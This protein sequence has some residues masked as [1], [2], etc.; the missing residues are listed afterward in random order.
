MNVLT[1]DDL[2]SIAPSI[3]TASPY[4]TMT[5]R[6]RV[7]HTA[8][9][10][11]VLERIGLFPVRAQQSRTRTPDRKPYVRHLIRFRRQQD[12]NADLATEIPEVVLSNSFDGTSAYR[13]NVGLF[14]V[15][16]LKRAGLPHRRAWGNLRPPRR[17]EP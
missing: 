14:R 8:D 9:A 13:L 15:A 16:C 12:I 5:P 1:R 3:F 6:Y 7:A 11:D 2:R 10:V 17:G 4:H